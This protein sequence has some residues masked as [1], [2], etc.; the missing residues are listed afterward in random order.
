VV[1]FI[2]SL[3]CWW[4]PNHVLFNLSLTRLFVEVIMPL[5]ST[6][7]PVDCQR[8]FGKA[9]ENHLG[10][11]SRCPLTDHCNGDLSR[12]LRRVTVALGANPRKG[13][14]ATNCLVCEQK[15]IE[16]NPVNIIMSRSTAKPR[17]SGFTAKRKSAGDN[18][19]TLN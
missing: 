6:I 12:L 15:S 13:N 19:L 7:S 11:E 5:F 17:I 2:F 18:S 1:E 3:F 4:T 10:R 16:E 8:R 14:R 9:T